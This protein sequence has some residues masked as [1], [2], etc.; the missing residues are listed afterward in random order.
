M[1][2]ECAMCEQEKAELESKN[3]HLHAIV[4][5]VR[6]E[7]VASGADHSCSDAACVLCRL[8]RMIEAMDTETEECLHAP[9]PCC[10]KDYCV[11]KCNGCDEMY[12]EKKR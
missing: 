5:V 7:I 1:T 3:V 2:I 6:D 11:C 12:V 9:E 8:R 10:A 4:D